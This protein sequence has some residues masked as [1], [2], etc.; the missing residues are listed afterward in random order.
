[1]SGTVGYYPGAQG[2][3]GGVLVQW[4]TVTPGTSLTVVVGSGGTGQTLA[5]TGSAFVNSPS[6]A[7]GASTISGPNIFFSANGGPGSVY[8]A[9]TTAGSTTPA[10]KWSVSPEYY[11]Y[12]VGGIGGS[13]S[14]NG[15]PGSP[16]AIIIEWID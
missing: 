1:M 12:G 7:G 16:G 13:P 2:G 11:L 6:T 15:S 14:G 4:V 3:P 5:W 9:S 10:Q 8:Y